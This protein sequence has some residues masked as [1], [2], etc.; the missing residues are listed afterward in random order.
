MSRDWGTRYIDNSLTVEKA[1]AKSGL[2]MYQLRKLIE[3]DAVIEFR[4]KNGKSYLSRSVVPDL[5]RLWSL[6]QAGL[7]EEIL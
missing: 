5:E 1:A 3:V 2:K 6:H 4:C 7:L